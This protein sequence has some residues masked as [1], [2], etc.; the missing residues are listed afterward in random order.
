MLYMN[1]INYDI[2]MNECKISSMSVLCPSLHI[3][4]GKKVIEGSEPIEQ[5]IVTRMG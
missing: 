1:I 4:S 2:G 5:S 3:Y